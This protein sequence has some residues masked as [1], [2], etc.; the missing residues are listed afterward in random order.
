[1]ALRE[2][3]G[4]PYPWDSGVFAGEVAGGRRKSG[5]SGARVRWGPLRLPKFLSCAQIGRAE[6]FAPAVRKKE[7]LRAAGKGE[8]GAATKKRGSMKGA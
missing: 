2:A 7:R 3:S 8:R 1:M 5:G 6:D 4:E